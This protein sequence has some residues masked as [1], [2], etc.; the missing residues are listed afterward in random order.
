MLSTIPLRVGDE[1]LR[2]QAE[3]GGDGQHPAFRPPGVEG[4]GLEVVACDEHVGD[5]LCD[6]NR[7]IHEALERLTFDERR[8]A[9]H[10]HPPNTDAARAPA[11]RPLIR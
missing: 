9:A 3:V 2:H 5:L 8:K 6:P 11:G 1:R 7:I 4:G 10:D